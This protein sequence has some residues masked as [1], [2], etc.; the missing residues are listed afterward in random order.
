MY[1]KKKVGLI[2]K[3]AKQ[4][5]EKTSVAGYIDIVEDN[6]PII[7]RIIWLAVNLGALITSTV[8]LVMSWHEFN[9]NPIVTNL[10][11]Q[12]YDVSDTPFPAVAICE[13]NQISKK[14]A[15]EYATIL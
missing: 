3:V 15:L 4:F 13:I 12:S 6:R 8:I 2:K 11:N 7:E 9:N 1:H 14:R 5:C 10:E